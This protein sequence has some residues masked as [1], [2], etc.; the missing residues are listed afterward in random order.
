MEHE[1]VRTF[2]DAVG[3]EWEVREIH[4]PSLAIVPRK[5]LRRPEY[6]DGWLLFTCGGERRRLAPCPGEWRAANT[7]ELA[8]WC[9]EAVRVIDREPRHELQDAAPPPTR[10]ATA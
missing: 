1:L 2:E 7:V 9:G 4:V 5:Y 10:Q 6:A 8:R 3:I